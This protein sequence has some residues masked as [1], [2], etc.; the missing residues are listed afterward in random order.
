MWLVKLFFVPLRFVL[1]AFQLP[2]ASPPSDS[3]VAFEGVAFGTRM[4][5][6]DEFVLKL[7]RPAP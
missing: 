6:S 1:V 7:S 3:Y 5:L 2:S 4:Q